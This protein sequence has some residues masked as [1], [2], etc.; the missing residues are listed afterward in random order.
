MWWLRVFGGQVDLGFWRED[1]A[2]GLGLGGL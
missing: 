1:R 2:V